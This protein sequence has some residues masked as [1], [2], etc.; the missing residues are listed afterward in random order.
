MLRKIAQGHGAKEI[1]ALLEVS[2]RTCETYRA[3]AMAK[4]GLKTRVDIVRYAL[5]QGWLKVN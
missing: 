1:A 2:T 4:L 3:R 5:E